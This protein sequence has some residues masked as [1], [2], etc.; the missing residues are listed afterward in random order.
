[1]ELGGKLNESVK[2]ENV[3]EP[4]FVPPNPYV[5]KV[6]DLLRVDLHAIHPNVKPKKGFAKVDRTWLIKLGWVNYK[7]AFTEEGHLRITRIMH[8]LPKLVKRSDAHS[9]LWRSYR[10]LESAVLGL[11]DYNKRNEA[12]QYLLVKPITAQPV[13]KQGEYVSHANFLAKR[14]DDSESPIE[15]FFAE[16]VYIYNEVTVCSPV[17]PRLFPPDIIPPLE[18]AKFK[19]ARVIHPEGFECLTC[20]DESGEPKEPSLKLNNILTA[21]MDLES[22]NT[23]PPKNF[24]SLTKRPISKDNG[25]SKKVRG[26]RNNKHKFVPRDPHM[27]RILYLLR[28]DLNAIDDDVKAKIGLAKIDR[29]WI[30]KLCAV[31]WSQA[32]TEEGHL[33]L[34]RIYHMLPKLV[35]R[36]DADPS[37]WKSYSRLKSAALALADYN[38]TNKGAEYELVRPITAQPSLGEEE[39]VS[40][41][42]FL[43]KRKHDPESHVELF[44]ASVSCFND[45]VLVCCPLEPRLFPPEIV[46]PLEKMRFNRGVVVHPEGFECSTCGERS[47]YL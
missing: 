12:A 44:F 42:N 40:H 24:P 19:P 27:A 21:T 34:T 31:A 9:S 6:I 26:S 7:H 10:C 37:L 11:A 45:D 1:M 47:I 3:S 8:M 18:N 16:V 4:T 15:L 33:R 43:A 20:N 36:A 17:E 28:V 13:V 2:S 35:N 30:S 32:F 14:K 22:S 46:P 29:K 38:K 25:K 39:Y 5:A 41:T 23:P